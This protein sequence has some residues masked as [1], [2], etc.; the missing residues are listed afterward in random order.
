MPRNASHVVMWPSGPRC[1]VPTETS[2]LAILV[3]LTRRAPTGRR[4]RDGTV[5]LMTRSAVAMWLAAS[6]TWTLTMVV[7]GRVGRPLIR[8]VSGSTWASPSGQLDPG[9]TAHR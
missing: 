6:V 5:A 1:L 3:R 8:P 7:P 2:S 4:Q 9:A